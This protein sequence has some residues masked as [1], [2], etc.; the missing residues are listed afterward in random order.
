MSRHVRV[1]PDASG[2]VVAIAL[3]GFCAMLNLH[4]PQP[5]LPLLSEAFSVSPTYAALTITV[6]A[7]AVGLVAPFAG[8]F[9]DARGRKPVIVAASFGI[10]LPTLACALAPNFGTLLAFRLLQGLFIPAVFTAILAYIAEEWDVGR[11]GRITSIYVTANVA[12]GFS[13]RFVAGVAADLGDWR[14]SFVA[15]GMI[16]LAGAVAIWWLLPPSRHF[17]SPVAQRNTFAQLAGHLGNRNIFAT[18]LVG[19]GIMFAFTGLMTYVAFYLRS[20]PFNLGPAELGAVF[21]TYVIASFSTPFAGPLIDRLGAKLMLVCA[22]TTM[23]IGSLLTSVPLLVVVLPGLV[24]CCAGMFTA[25]ASCMLYTTRSVTTGRSAA[26]GLY[27][28]FYYAGAAFGATI[29]GFAFDRGG[30]IACATLASSVAV[31]SAI[32][33]RL[34]W[35]DDPSPAASQSIRPPPA[36]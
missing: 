3:C 32:T 20:A 12:G 4:A 34:L 33:A 13:G 21:L 28:A 36:P 14:L 24:L 9:S 30:W 16:A 17:A 31:I 19:L 2:S 5:I 29:P 22:A 27:L 25:Q 26:V 8:A 11:R 10:A 6:G 35:R 1:A 18:C 15:L 23:A 7:L